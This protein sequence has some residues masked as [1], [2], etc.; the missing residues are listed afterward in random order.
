MNPT[1]NDPKTTPTGVTIPTTVTDQ[2]VS[3]G[4]ITR[5]PAEGKP[6]IASDYQ[7]AAERA[8]LT[9]K[10]LNSASK[11]AAIAVLET[12]LNNAQEV[13]YF[14][15]NALAKAKGG[16]GQEGGNATMNNP[17]DDRHAGS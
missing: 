1:Q 11:A 2:T 12:L 10:D 16:T 6:T 4:G 9:N 15:Q 13:V 17:F 3:S 8:I 7:T 5:P 14:L